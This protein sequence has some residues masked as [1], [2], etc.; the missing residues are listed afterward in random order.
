MKKHS[1]GTVFP[2]DM[3]K[4]LCSYLEAESLRKILCHMQCDHCCCLDGC[5]YVKLQTPTAKYGV[6]AWA[7]INDLLNLDRGSTGPPHIKVT[8]HAFPPATRRCPCGSIKE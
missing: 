7:L 2:L 4:I 5:L 3:L 8:F 6:C 1:K